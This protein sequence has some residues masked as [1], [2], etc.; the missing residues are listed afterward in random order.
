MRLPRIAVAAC[1]LVACGGDDDSSTPSDGRRPDGNTSTIDAPRVPPDADLSCTPVQGTPTL[2]TQDVVT[3]GLVMP[4]FVTSPPGDPRLFVLEKQGRVRVIKDGQ[5]LEEPFL[6]VPTQTGGLSDERGL[7]SIAFPPDYAQSRKVY[8]FYTAE[9]DA[10]N[11]NDD[12]VEMYLADP[13]NPDRALPDSGQLVIRVEDFAGNHN[14]G[15][16]AFRGDFLY[17]SVGDGGG[18]GDPEETG[19]DLNESLG[20]IHRFDVSTL[21]AT[22]A[23]GNPFIGDTAGL[24]TIWSYGWRNPWRFSF[25]RET[26]DMYIGDVGQDTYEEV[27]VEAAND[28]GGKNYGWDQREGKHCH[29]PSSGCT[30]AGMTEPVFEYAQNGQIGGCTVVG[31][32]VYRGCAMPGYHGTYFFTDY[33]GGWVRSFKWDG[34][35]GVT[36]VTVHEGLSGS[37]RVSFGQD[38][39]GELYLVEQESGDI[40]KIVPQP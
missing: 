17:W 15:T 35:G 32:Y 19:Q 34:A 8:V 6:T 37:S 29:E 11:D 31:G 9:T 39:A 38:A 7:L 18:G 36:D 13:A 4:T 23:A 20:K 22:A 10:T 25:D 21:P 24:D 14:G 28:A 33:C 2:T 26:G 27:D 12:V 40:V 1:L 5:L 3:S 16:L 30:T